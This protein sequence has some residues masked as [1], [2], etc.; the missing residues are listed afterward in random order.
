MPAHV[1]VLCPARVCR[2]RNWRRASFGRFGQ[3]PRDA[4]QECARFL[5]LSLLAAEAAAPLGTPCLRPLCF[6]WRA[7][8]QHACGCRWWWRWRR[9]RRHRRCR[10]RRHDAGRDAVRRR[11]NGTPPPIAPLAPL[12]SAAGFPNQQRA[13]LLAATGRDGPG[14]VR[15]DRGLPLAGRPRRHG[16]RG[17]HG[18]WLRRARW[19]A[20]VLCGQPRERRAGAAGVQGAGGRL[21]VSG[22]PGGRRRLGR[23]PC[24][25]F[26]CAR[27]AGWGFSTAA[28]TADVAAADAAAAAVPAAADA[29]PADGS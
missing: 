4:E 14:D 27:W 1:C 20:C 6:V 17:R 7:V 8:Y 23:R 26:P 9:W 11:S 18:R 28:A 29:E 10:P 22:R 2:R 12:T 19:R 16:R 25:G 5:L 15:H 24:G 13:R 21:P 3:D